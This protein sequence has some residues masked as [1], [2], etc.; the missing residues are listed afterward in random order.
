MDELPEQLWHR[1][2]RDACRYPVYALGWRFSRKQIREELKS[3][4]GWWTPSALVTE[5]FLPRWEKYRYNLYV[6]IFHLY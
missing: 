2:I 5:L 1:T 6:Y 4:S 3:K